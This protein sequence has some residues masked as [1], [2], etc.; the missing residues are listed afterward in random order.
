[1]STGPTSA[2]PRPRLLVISATYAWEEP[3]KKL[4]AL[5]DHFALT[6]LTSREFLSALGTGARVDA[7]T[8]LPSRGGEFTYRLIGL[9]PTGR[10]ASTTKYVLRGLDRA[11]AACPADLILVESEPW[12]AVRWQSWR[13]RRHQPRA[14]FGE[15]SWENSARTGL[16]GAVLW[17]AYRAAARTDD[18]V[19]TGNAE[20]GGLF[21]RHGL[22]EER[23]LVSPQLGVDEGVFRPPAPD[24]RAR[25]R[26]DRLGVS[27]G[28][29][30]VGFAGRLEASKGLWD[31]LAAVEA[32]RVQQ[33][34]ADVRLCLL[35]SGALGEELVRRAAG[36]AAPW[37][38]ILPPAEHAEVA[39]FMQGIDLFVLPS[40]ETGP[41]A[42]HWK[43]QFGHVLIEATACG[44]PTLGSDSGAIPEVLARPDM[45]FPWREPA[46]LTARL[47]DLVALPADARAE[48]ARDQR[49][50]TLAHY[51]H[52]RLAEDWA[53]FLRARLAGHR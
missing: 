16:K 31:L 23:L 18:F 48:I 2:D 37:L 33:P 11:V 49:R 13:A 51:T 39:A 22:P 43:E 19:I 32:V 9:E 36:E 3:R 24:E 40:Q 53:A 52:Q 5:A 1:M 29:F 6:C 20:A 34:D 45:I 50:H 7:E 26:R 41:P 21:R 44:T 17:A 14:M 42:E 25:V 8:I 38:R 46:R 30:V 47:S 28:S 10:P 4:A 27:G 35:G 12:A 15:F